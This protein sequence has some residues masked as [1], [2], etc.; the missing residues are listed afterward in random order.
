M[1]L[2]DLSVIT[3][4]EARFS[5]S[6]M[7]IL[8]DGEGPRWSFEYENFKNDPSPDILLLGAYKNPN[9]GNNLVGGINIH[10][11][12]SEQIEQLARAL[13][14]I[15]QA[16]N[17]YNRYHIGKRLLPDIFDNFYRT[18]NAA[19]INNVKQN[20]MYPKY[21]LVKTA[22]N[23]IKNKLAAL[24]KSRQEREQDIEVD[25]PEDLQLMR[26]RL[27][28]VVTDLQTE[29]PP[30]EVPE[31]ELQSAR[32]EYQ[33]LKTITRPKTDDQIDKIEDLPVTREIEDYESEAERT[34]LP[35][36]E[37][38]VQQPAQRRAARRPELQ[39][40]DLQ[41]PELQQPELQQ[42]PVLQE[43]E[44]Q[45]RLNQQQIRDVLQQRRLPNQQINDRPASRIEPRISDEDVPELSA[46]EPQVDLADDIESDREKNINDLK[47][48]DLSE[49]IVYY[50][51]YLK[52]YVIE[53][54]YLFSHEL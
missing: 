5:L 14:R 54:A 19:Y 30:A 35:D 10:Y 52:R 44:A 29:K 51:P 20:V 50:S 40:P 21:G 28:Q 27:D 26:D 53:P 11:L 24:R 43:P 13:P 17:L 9:T 36:Q 39:Q 32:D 7:T 3:V 2:K 37:V 34:E 49:S 41:Q 46:P 16:R 1:I 47:D 25:Y 42:E 31:P 8:E 22:A 45:K 23:W 6:D 4:E 38:Q 12:S 18:Y 33:R 48:N 15:M